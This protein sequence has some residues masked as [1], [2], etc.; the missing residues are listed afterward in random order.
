[1]HTWL[2]LGQIKINWYAA[3]DQKNKVMGVGIIARDHNG[4]V[5][6]SMCTITPY[7]LNSTVA[8]ALAAWQGVEFCHDFEIQFIMLE[9]D[10]KEIV[11]V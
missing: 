3:M 9:G 1:M 11:L 4:H 10:T 6:A 5:R 2:P 7:V 8:E